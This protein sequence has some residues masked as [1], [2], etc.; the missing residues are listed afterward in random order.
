MKKQD[1]N[2]DKSKKT[3][4]IF[5]AISLGLLAIG[6]YLLLTYQPKTVAQQFYEDRK[7]V[8]Y[9]QEYR[10]SQSNKKKAE[11]NIFLQD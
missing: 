6:A 9:Y 2:Q 7:S 8:Q 4:Y 1:S 10:D 11:R 3:L 5:I